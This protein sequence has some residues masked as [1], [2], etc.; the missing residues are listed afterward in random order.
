[1]SMFRG[2]EDELGIEPGTLNPT[3]FGS[4]AWEDTLVGRT[5][6][7]E[8]WH[9]IG[10]QLNL[11]TPEAIDA[12]RQRYRADEALNEDVAALIRKL[13]AE[14]RHKL[15]VLSNSP[16]GLGRWLEE[17]GLLGCFEVVFCSGDEGVKKPDAAAFEITLERL[18]VAPE[19]AVFIDDTPGHIDAARSLGIHGVLFTTAEVLTDDLDRLLTMP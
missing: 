13:H 6:S 18:S 16:P 15:A 3:M 19:E 7:E 11:H 1:M 12:F 5:T 8:F 14:G 4:Q 2:Y 17:W 9:A 10:P